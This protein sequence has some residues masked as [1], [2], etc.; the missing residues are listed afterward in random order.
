MNNTL[1]N[2]MGEIIGVADVVGGDFPAGSTQSSNLGVLTVNSTLP[3]S[4]PS[5]QNGA[6]VLQLGNVATNEIYS[7]N[8]EFWS[9]CPGVMSIPALPTS[10]NATDACQVLYVNN[11]NQNIGIAYRDTRYLTGAG[12]LQPGETTIYAPGSTARIKCGI[13]NSVTMGNTGSSGNKSYM[14]IGANGGFYVFTPFG[15]ISLDENGFNVQVVSGCS[16]TMGGIGLPGPFAALGG[17][18]TLTSPVVNVMSPSVSLGPG[19]VYLP[20]SMPLAPAPFGTPIPMFGSTP[21]N[22]VMISAL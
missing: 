17:I 5:G 10:S 22:S 2:M 11:N 13:D 8:T 16:L 3:S 12:T 15:V 6:S 14:Q 4:T 1:I 19:P 21:S 7:K 9:G 18:I 20:A